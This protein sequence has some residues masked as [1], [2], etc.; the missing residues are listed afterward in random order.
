[1]ATNIS[2]PIFRAGFERGMA[3]A[4]TQ[5]L[6]GVLHT[7]PLVTSG[8]PSSVRRPRMRQGQK[9]SR[10]VIARS[11][12]GLET[13]FGS[14]SF[15]TETA[16]IFSGPKKVGHEDDPVLYESKTIFRLRP[17]AW[18]IRMGLEYTV[19]LTIMSNNQGWHVCPEVIRA[20]P[21]QSEIAIACECGDLEWIQY[22]F[23]SGRASMRDQ[24]PGGYTPLHVNLITIERSKSHIW[25]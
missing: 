6:A 17:A 22:L 25:R 18:L 14:V 11:T 9:E 7:V 16:H 3:S 21:A 19:N 23:A 1:M 10:K 24:I 8:K 13:F 15:I 20:V 2:N 4:L 5:A 12:K